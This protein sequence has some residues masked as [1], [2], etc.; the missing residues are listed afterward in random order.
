MSEIVQ[1]GEADRRWMRHA[2]TLGARA[3]RGVR[4]NPA[5]GCVVVADGRMVGEGHHQRLGGPHAE[6]HA[7]KMAGE[8]ARG[9]TAYVTLE[10]C[11]HHGRTPPCVDAL[12]AAGVARV[13]VG[14]ADTT[15]SAAGGAERLRGAGVQV[16]VG[17]EGEAAARLAEVFLVNHHHERPFVRLKM[18]ASLDGYTAASDGSSRWLTGA[19]ARRR[20][21]RWRAD[22]DAVMVGSGTALADDPRLDLRHGVPGVP[23]LRVVADRR[24]R[25][26]AGLRLADTTTQPTIVLCTPASARTEQAATLTKRGVELLPVAGEEELCREEPVGHVGSISGMRR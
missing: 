19:E 6:V 15:P 4:P 16:D 26:G 21:H 14:V 23:P 8:L 18:A 22:A 13:V 9:A 11:N 17:V 25:I 7:L 5:V 24:L 12:I 1:P 20:V 2:V 10:P 3:D